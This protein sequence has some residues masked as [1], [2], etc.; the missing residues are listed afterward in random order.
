MTI[1]RKH[2]AESDY[3][4]ATDLRSIRI[5]KSVLRDLL[6]QCNPAIP[7]EEYRQVMGLLRGWE[8][9]LEYLTIPEEAPDDWTAEDLR[10][11][12]EAG[13]G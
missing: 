5:A 9:R 10:V 12:R 1:R 11:L 3:I 7:Q 2:M 13:Q 8:R 4:R 6:P